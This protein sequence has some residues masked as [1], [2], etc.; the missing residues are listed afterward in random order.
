MPVAT[1]VPNNVVAP[2]PARHFGFG[3]L[4]VQ[5]CKTIHL[6]NS[7]RITISTLEWKIDMGHLTMGITL[8]HQ[9]PVIIIHTEDLMPG[10]GIMAEGLTVAVA[11]AVIT[12][13]KRFCHGI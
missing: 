6:P 9:M 10:A 2:L 11:A 3:R 4:I 13:L 7:H 12:R 1:E 5:P 8:R